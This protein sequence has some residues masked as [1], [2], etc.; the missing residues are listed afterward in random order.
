MLT[1]ILESVLPIDYFPNFMLGLLCDLKIVGD[2]LKYHNP[3]VWKKLQAINIDTSI[4]LT[5]WLV[6]MFTTAA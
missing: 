4:I 1:Y 3:R 5:H 2:L 6:C